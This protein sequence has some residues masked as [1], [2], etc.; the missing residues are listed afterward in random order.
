MRSTDLR[1]YQ[2]TAKPEPNAQLVCR[3]H[4]QCAGCPYP[5]HGFV[6]WGKEDHCIRTEMEK[7]NRRNA[8]K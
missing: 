2:P 1:T 7:V 6:C 5:A 8:G 4:L 3:E